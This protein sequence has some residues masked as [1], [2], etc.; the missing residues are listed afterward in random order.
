M[1][2]LM[3]VGMQEFRLETVEPGNGCAVLRVRGEVDVF[4]APLLRERLL[5]LA[6]NGAVHVIVDL[7]D[8]IFL[9]ST[10]LGVLVGGLK[11]VRAH[12]GSLRLVISAERII[13]IFR[14]TGLLTVLSPHQTLPDA[15]AADPHW[16]RTA[17]REAGS[18]EEW[19]RRHGLSPGRLPGRAEPAPGA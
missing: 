2:T 17:E 11:R 3:G 18:V 1:T 8:V 7:S 12:N 6:E 14:I 5:D 9:D 13:R 10:G 16:R 4:T 15:V 19:C